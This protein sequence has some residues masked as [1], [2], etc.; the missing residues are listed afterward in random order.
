MTTENKLDKMGEMGSEAMENLKENLKKLA[1][2]NTD[3]VKELTAKQM[4]DF[5]FIMDQTKR[6]VELITEVKDLQGLK[7]F[8]EAQTTVLKDTGG[9]LVD[10]AKD[11]MKTANGLQE[12]YAAF[13]KEQMEEL[14]K[15]F[16]KV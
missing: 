3:T 9:H 1:E 15:K 12:K 13:L 5:Q 7:D 8:F 4:E 6:Q 16:R 14:T 10:K 11:S 2:L